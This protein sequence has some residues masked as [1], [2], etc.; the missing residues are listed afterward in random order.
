MCNYSIF[1]IILAERKT[2]QVR[3]FFCIGE[4]VVGTGGCGD[5]EAGPCACPGEGCASP[6]GQAQAPRLYR[7]VHPLSLLTPSLL[8]FGKK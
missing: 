8:S 4:Y 7:H 5:A 2:N 3:F 1:R 6:R